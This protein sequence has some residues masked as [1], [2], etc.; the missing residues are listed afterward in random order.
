M[1]SEKTVGVLGDYI[2]RVKEVIPYNKE[3]P[4]KGLSVDKKFIETNIANL[5][6]I[7]VPFQLV[8]KGQFA[9]APVTSRNGDKLSLAFNSS[10]E[11][12][13]ISTTYMVFQVIKPDL[14]NCLYLELF[15]KQSWIDKIARYASTGT[16]RETLSFESFFRFP[17]VAPNLEV[18]E[19]I[20]N[21]Y[22]T[23]T[24]YIEVKK[25]INELLERK[26]KAYFHILF[27]DLKDYEMKS[28]GE[29]FTIIR[30]G[31][32]PKFNKYLKELYFC[33]EGG[34]PW[35]KVEDISEYKFVN[36]TSEQLTQEG[37]KKEGCKLIT[38]KDLIFI[39]SA[40]RER[41]GNVYIISHNLTI[42]ESFWTLSNNLLVGGGINIDCL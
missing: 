36:H 33:K 31:Q 3:I 29:L 37:F 7:V 40:G 34:I 15:F 20:V 39:R 32:P 30:G 19:K 10:W 11:Q 1:R 8:K 38:P 9:Y 6:G 42:N 22:Q 16:V 35:L 23:V 18:Q 27:D 28:F 13:Q 17:I 12:I 25:R 5:D 2:E 14:L 26:M 4:V 21:K 24:K 41:A